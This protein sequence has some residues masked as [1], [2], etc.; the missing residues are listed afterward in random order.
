MTTKPKTPKKKKPVHTAES[1]IV[2]GVE[3]ARMSIEEFREFNRWRRLRAHLH[4]PLI[5][6]R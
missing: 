4:G 6:N 3:T 2:Q 1:S 5:W